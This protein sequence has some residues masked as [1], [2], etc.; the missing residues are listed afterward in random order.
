[1][2]KKNQIKSKQKTCKKTDGSWKTSNNFI[3]D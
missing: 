1:M 2:F 3:G